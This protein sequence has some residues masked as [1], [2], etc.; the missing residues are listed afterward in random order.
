[1]GCHTLLP[2]SCMPLRSSRLIHSFTL[3]GR[4]GTLNGCIGVGN[5]PKRTLFSGTCTLKSWYQSSMLP[6]M[7]ITC[8][9]A[10]HCLTHAAKSPHQ[11]EL[12]GPCRRVIWYSLKELSG[13]LRC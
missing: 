10:A 9:R 13:C 11:A 6:H 12:A 2:L 3:G 8:K 5:M 4:S 7:R 1:M